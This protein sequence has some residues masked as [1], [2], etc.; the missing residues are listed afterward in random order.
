[1]DWNEIY[2]LWRSLGKPLCNEGILR[3]KITTGRDEAHAIAT[4]QE[5]IPTVVRWMSAS[6]PHH[7]YPPV[8]VPSVRVSL[9]CKYG[10]AAYKRHC[11][12]EGWKVPWSDYLMAQCGLTFRSGQSPNLWTMFNNVGI[13]RWNR[14]ISENGRNRVDGQIVNRLNKQQAELLSGSSRWKKLVEDWRVSRERLTRTLTSC[15]G[16]SPAT[17]VLLESHVLS[18]AFLIA[19]RD[20]IAAIDG[21]LLS[22]GTTKATLELLESLEKDE[23]TSRRFYDAVI[24]EGAEL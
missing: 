22:E 3:V 21:G 5:L 18:P 24:M 12:L 9:F 15:P 2:S 19:D 1:M 6:Y 13:E 4:V 7:D 10:K 23:Y 8:N 17:A 14:Y 20:G 11:E 16:L